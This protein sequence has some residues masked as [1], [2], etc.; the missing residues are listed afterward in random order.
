M[1]QDN[2]GRELELCTKVVEGIWSER[3]DA[4]LSSVP[5]MFQDASLPNLGYKEKIIKDAVMDMFAA[6]GG[7]S[8][9]IG[10][11]F[12]G[13]PGSGKTYASYAV[14]KWV[15]EMNP[16]AVGLVASYADVVQKLRKEFTSDAYEDYGSVWERLNSNKLIFLDDLS[17]QK[18][19]DFETDKLLAFMDNRMN[20]YMPFLFTTNARPDEFDRVFGERLA[21]R[22]WG[23]CKMIEF[24]DR[25][26]RI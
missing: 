24:E 2:P 25:D 11:I 18:P 8:K 6:D 22:F 13:N 5:Q 23:F 9:N 20:N 14:L 10:V 17:S 3:S 21:S 15:C 19:T 16:E 1:M 26:K 7:K 12:T 4:L